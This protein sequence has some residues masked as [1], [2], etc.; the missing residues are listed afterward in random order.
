MANRF[1]V[2]QGGPYPHFVTFT[3]V[4]WYPVFTSGPYFKIVLDSLRHL[5]ENRDLRVH[6]YVVMP[7]HMHA[8]LTSD[9]DDLS[10]AIRDFKRFTARSIE[11]QSADDG[12]R[13]MSW[14]FADSAKDSRAKSKVWQD[15]S[16]PEVVYTR[17]FF[18]QK[19]DYIHNNPLRKGL[20]R[21]PG[22]YYYSSFAAFDRGE[23]D[24]F[25]IDWI[26]W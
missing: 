3:I 14:L 17:D 7:T 2:V 16:Q 19:A 26:E 12:N 21:E 25:E 15:E 5:R 6:A 18:L 10:A 22:Q 4:R 9:N 23:M 13:L 24:P 20:A 8:I 11:Q 1:K